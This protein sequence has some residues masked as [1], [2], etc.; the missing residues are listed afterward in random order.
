[1]YCIS[2]SILFLCYMFSR[3]KEH[4]SGELRRSARTKVYTHVGIA[5][6]II[7]MQESNIQDIDLIKQLIVT[8]VDDNLWV[9]KYI[10]TFSYNYYSNYIALLQEKAWGC[11]Q[12]LSSARRPSCEYVL[13]N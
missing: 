1:M 12:L 11:M 8:S 3:Q 13:E 5:C 9:G 4:S 2:H 6:L 10:S 7:N